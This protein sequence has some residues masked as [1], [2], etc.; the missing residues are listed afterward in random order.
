MSVSQECD[1]GKI[2]SGQGRCDVCRKFEILQVNIPFS[3]L[4]QA[5]HYCSV[6]ALINEIVLSLYPLEWSKDKIDLVVL[7]KDP[8]MRISVMFGDRARECKQFTVYTPYPAEGVL[9]AWSLESV[10]T[11]FQQLS[12]LR[13]MENP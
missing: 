3:Y 12:C 10:L 1:D 5:S 8:R 2:W 11:V 9:S 13:A 4:I 6:C 7:H